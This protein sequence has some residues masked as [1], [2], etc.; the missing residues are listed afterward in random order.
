MVR[1]AWPGWWLGLLVGIGPP[2]AA[3]QARESPAFELKENYPNPLFASTTIP[4]TLHQE[5]CRDGHRPTVSLEVRNVIAQV[6]AVPVLIEEP[7]RRVQSLR[8]R[9][10]EYR[11]FWDGRYDD[12]EREATTGVYWYRLT[13]DGQAQTRKM[14]VQRRVTSSVDARGGR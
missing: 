1:F 11:A 7:A 4:F 13:V 2:A 5:A 14:I 8:L 6:V 9:C 3:Q 10:G 12:G